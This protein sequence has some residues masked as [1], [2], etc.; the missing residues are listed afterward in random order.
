MM[1]AARRKAFDPVNVTSAR[2][3]LDRCNTEATLVRSVA[4]LVHEAIAR[5]NDLVILRES[6]VRESLDVIH[7]IV[8]DTNSD[9][10]LRGRQKSVSPSD[11][12]LRLVVGRYEWM[13]M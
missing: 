9:S 2:Q 3:T 7:S 4:S 11:E 8:F 13:R 5:A 1:L 6:I 10:S 12:R